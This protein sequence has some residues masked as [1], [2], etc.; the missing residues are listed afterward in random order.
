MY[1]SDLC[2]T[3]VSAPAALQEAGR[4][5]ALIVIDALS[6]RTEPEV[7]IVTERVR[8]AFDTLLKSLD[9]AALKVVEDAAPIAVVM[10]GGN[11]REALRIAQARYE[12]AVAMALPAKTGKRAWTPI[13]VSG[14]LGLG[15][16]SVVA[17]AWTGSQRARRR[18]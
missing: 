7:V 17:F 9:C 4:D 11:V 14:L 15:V 3:G 18:R 10:A 5:L 8:R 1:G 13:I 12:L 6:A 16:A 2:K